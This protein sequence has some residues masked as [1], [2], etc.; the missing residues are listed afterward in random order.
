V[1]AIGLLFGCRTASP[2]AAQIHRPPDPAAMVQVDTTDTLKPIWAPQGVILAG[3]K[4]EWVSFA[5]E[6]RN[7]SPTSSLRL[8]A[9][10]TAT[11][12][13]IGT[14]SLSVYQVLPM[15]VDTNTA[16]Y[17]RYT[18]LPTSD[19]PLPRALLPIASVGGLVDLAGLRD[20]SHPFDP[21]ARPAGRVGQPVILWIDIHVPAQ[22]L[23]GD[24]A[25]ACELLGKNHTTPIARLNVSVH[26]NSF[27][28]PD[29]RHLQMVSRVDW[30]SLERLYPDRFEAITPRLLNRTDD[31]YTGAIRTL[32]QLEQLAQANRVEVVF[33][34]LQPTV[35][36]PAGQPPEV[37]W[38][39]FDSVISPWMSGAAFPDKIPLGYWSL[40]TI[41]YLD[42]YDIPSR[43]DYWANAATHFNAQDW[44]D[45]CP[46]FMQNSTENSP[47]GRAAAPGSVQISS[48]AAQILQAHPGVR[49]MAPLEDE[50]LQFASADHPDLLDPSDTWRIISA[51]PG[52]V[53]ASPTHSWP[54]G[55]KRPTH[56]LRTDTSGVVPYVGA[57]DNERDVRI[58]AWLAFLRH[59]DLILWGDALPTQNQPTQQADPN[60]LVW[61]YPGSWFGVDGPVPSVQLKWLRR[62]QQDYECLLLATQRGMSS[63][64]LMLA[65][66]MTKQV[67]IEP[68]QPPDPLYDLLS[69]T[70]EQQTWDQAQSLLARAIL[71]HAPGQSAQNATAAQET[72][73]NLDMIRWQQP[74]ERPFILP[75]VA[76]WYLD[77][78]PDSNGGHWAAVRLGVDVYNASDNQPD[79]NLLQWTSA[80]E[81]W[82]FNPKPVV[83]DALR[84]YSVRRFWLPAVVDLDHIGPS[85]RQP[86]E[87]SFVDGF[88]RNEYR[89]QTSLPVAASDR[90]EG[91]LAIDGKLDQWYSSD[92]IHDGQLT[93]MLDR[94]SVQAWRIE[95]ASAAS[96]VFTTWADDNFYL[97]FRVSGVTVPQPQRN[98]VDF[99]FRRAWGEDLCEALIQPINDDNSPG[100]ITYLACKPGGVCVI[101]RRADSRAGPGTWQEIAGADVR[102]AANASAAGWTGDLAIPWKLILPGD[103]PRPRVLRFNFIQHMASNGESASWAGPI[104]F[105]M[106][107]S[108]MGLIFLRDS[109]APGMSAPGR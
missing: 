85:S 78:S 60:D 43:R 100:P 101:K 51:S 9:L 39:D 109:G 32:D 56:W 38:S 42:N 107:V 52:P 12:Q 54:A 10:Q 27:A 94:P 46:V 28:I 105:D 58:W 67:E 81:G 61:F 5:V 106:D 86:L 25:A 13:T 103:R 66:L 69:S 14:S 64:A 45:R 40:P 11:K 72:A 96:Q 22:A 62:A 48:L 71:L 99:Q 35:K 74:K 23:A 6:I 44:L 47:P 82:E 41:D 88:T 7:A 68:A 49:V 55:L 30:E 34:R 92:L 57:V 16:G 98:F 20:P 89:S 90:R 59:A 104:D 18:G 70:V 84:M 19:Q 21:A 75:R 31:V 108:Y 95:P 73:L 76:N 26:V 79:Q 24:Y 37:D 53:F 4:N 91:H 80:G 65:R 1:I 77:S 102:Y 97:G 87:I 3:A 17:V 15:P 93:R 8:S 36:W 2:Q 63:D 83:L 33:P 29:E 50:Q